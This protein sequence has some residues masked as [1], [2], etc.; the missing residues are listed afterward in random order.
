MAEKN[1]GILKT[2]WIGTCGYFPESEK[3]R[4]TIEELLRPYNCIPLFLD[5]PLLNKVCLFHELIIR[6]LFH[7]FKGMNEFSNDHGSADLFEAYLKAN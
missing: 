7:N 2:T 1:P 3:E 5:P 4:A 6:P